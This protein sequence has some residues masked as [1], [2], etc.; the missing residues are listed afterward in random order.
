VSYDRNYSHQWQTNMGDLIFAAAFVR[1]YFDHHERNGE[2]PTDEQ[3]KS[4]AEES[5]GVA[6]H[7]K[8]AT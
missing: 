2:W 4:M 1:Q 5:E 3:A 7:W 8:E 6:E